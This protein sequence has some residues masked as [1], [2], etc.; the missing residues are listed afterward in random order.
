MRHLVALSPG[1]VV[2]LLARAPALPAQQP[3]DTLDLGRIY[4][5][6]D[7]SNGAPVVDTLP[8]LIQCPLFDPRHIRGDAATFSFERRP[9]VEEHMPPVR[10][11]LE[12]VVDPGGRVEQHTARVVRSSDDR[13]NRSFEYWVRDCRFRPGKIRGHAVR[14]Q[15][16]RE[17]EIQPGR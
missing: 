17:W 3:A 2:A 16:Q 4:S 9:V 14:V 7:S 13:L 1:I 10:V 8:R 15:M 11:T 12:F 5:A 6:S